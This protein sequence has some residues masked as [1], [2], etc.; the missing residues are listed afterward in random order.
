MRFFRPKLPEVHDAS[1]L[2]QLLIEAVRTQDQRMLADL[3]KTHQDMIL[4]HFT[5]WTK[6]P[7]DIR[8]NQTAI[9]LYVNTLGAVAQFF[10]TQLGNPGPFQ[11]LVGPE[12]TNPLAEWQKA[13]KQAQGYM[14]ELHYAEAIQTLSDLLLKLHGLTGSGVD[15]Y[16]PITYG[17]LGESYF[18]HGEASK[19]ISP[20]ETARRLCEQQGDYEGIG[21]YEGNLY[22]IHRYLGQAEAAAQ[23]AERLAQILDKQEQKGEAA[24]YR[25]QAQRVRLGESLNRVV[26]HINGMQFE[27]SEIRQIDI[28][29]QR[30]Q[31][32]FQRNR[33]SLRA[34]RAFIDQ[35]EQLARK[36][37]FGDA[38]LAF[39]NATKVDQ[40][41]PQAP[42]FAGLTLLNLQRYIEAAESYETTERLAPGWYNCRADLWIAR[43][44]AERNISHEI[45]MALHKLEDW[46]LDPKE[47]V[48]LAEQ[49]LAKAPNLA[50]LYLFY[51]KGLSAIQRT[52]D[53]EAAYRKGLACVEEPDIKTR[54][55]LQLG[56][57]MD[58]AS[59]RE[60]LLEQAV[61]VNGNL[62][63]A[64]MAVVSLA[65]TK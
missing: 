63:A 29:N 25:R 49:S 35:G 2:R 53:A 12:K 36:N 46:P 65:T 33:I 42:Y 18:Q 38:L 51:G 28:R 40:Y 60:Q 44:L 21:A 50:P 39:Q 19:A 61:E 30:V 6:A 22:E 32:V 5:E 48:Q 64:A 54:L 37:N 20:I 26:V 4:R 10:A 7:S 13:L 62:V 1:Q 52:K 43:Q 41:D 47:K 27:L 14:E 11:Q 45:F 57:M 58:S 34:A 8:S 56:T 9:Q 59:E 16:L 24:K 55:L 23:A 31:F 15:K 17:Y 3:C